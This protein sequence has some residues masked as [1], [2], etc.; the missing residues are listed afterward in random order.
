MCG[1]AGKR[2]FDSEP[3]TD[4]GDAMAATMQHRGPNADGIFCDRDVVLSHC[5]LSILDTTTAG[6]QPMSNS[7]ETIHIVFNGEIYNYQEL[8]DQH[9][10]GYSFKSETDTEVLLYLYEE[11]GIECLNELRGMFAF[12]IWDERTERLVV[13]RDRLGQKPL[14][15]H[16]SDTAFRFGS[17]IKAVLADSDVPARPDHRAIREYLAYQYV[18]HPRTGFE[19]I[20]KLG[21]GEYIIIDDNEISH[22]SY[23]SLPDCDPLSL[24]KETTQQR[25]REHVREAVRLRLRSD[26]P[27]GVF[28]SGGLDSSITVAMMDDLGV[29]NI[30]TFSIGFDVAEYDETNYAK[31]VAD[32]YDTDHHEFEVSPKEMAALPELVDH[33]EMP[34]GD[35][36][37]L[38]T[39]FV[40]QMA[41][42]H[43]TVALT[44]DAGDENFAGYPQYAN[45]KATSLASKVP[46]LITDIGAKTI[47]SLPR[48][49]RAQIPREKDA[50]RILRLAAKSKPGRYAA[51]VGHF[52]EDDT[53]EVYDGPWKR[54]V[55]D[56]FR[57]QFDTTPARTPVDEATGVD[58]RSYLPEDL[59]VKVDRASMAHSIEVRSPFLDHEL[60]EFARRIPAAQKMPRF[61]KKVVLKE[62]F[63][64]YLPD[65]V[66]DREKQGFGVPVGEWFRGHLKNEGREAIERLGEREAWDEAGLEK[67]WG[68]HQD[69][70]Q[71]DGKHLWDLV[72]LE[73]WYEQY[74]D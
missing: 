8:K 37:A 44:G 17:T 24:S 13:A 14:F 29:E 30:K 33:F 69:G 58:L 54:E 11:L 26:V 57:E 7:D 6:T 25:L 49:I 48:A 12:G 3:N 60:V 40:S 34:F 70:R 65:A 27:L 53:A 72:F 39:Y 22:D 5:R 63:R 10:E 1:I 74:I 66:V 35:A 16:H 61:N 68:A 45:Y 9:L 15:Y 56:W 20:K 21:P 67:K 42:N 46:D 43:I 51:L 62:A 32:R 4:L 52:T 41:S 55:L 73:E 47:R 19:G 64:P 31:M 38:P 59:L 23:W 36:S 18:P 2:V 71:N 50:E 28:L